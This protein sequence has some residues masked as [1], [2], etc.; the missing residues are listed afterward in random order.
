MEAE[1]PFREIFPV[2]ENLF[3]MVRNTVSMPQAEADAE[4]KV[5]DKPLN[6]EE[7]A[8]FREALEEIKRGLSSS[9]MKN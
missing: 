9:P 8:G 1:L 7:I 5:D 3:D 4:I 2:T 6:D